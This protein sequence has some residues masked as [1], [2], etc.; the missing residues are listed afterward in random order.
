MS[1]PASFMGP[2]YVKADAETSSAHEYWFRS[3]ASDDSVPVTA[4][5]VQ[6]LLK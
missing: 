3:L 4:C 1:V 5:E 2:L 6:I